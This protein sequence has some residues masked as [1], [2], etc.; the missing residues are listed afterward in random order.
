MKHLFFVICLVT[1]LC[2]S[3]KIE[4]FPVYNTQT[5]YLKGNVKLMIEKSQA[6]HVDSLLNYTI[7]TNRFNGI[8][9]YFYFSPLLELDSTLF[10]KMDTIFFGKRFYF[11]TSKTSQMFSS[12]YTMKGVIELETKISKYKNNIL[13]TKNYAPVLGYHSKTEEKWENSKIVWSKWESKL[14][15][16]YYEQL[17]EFDSNG[18]DTI[19]KSR[20]LKNDPFTI[21][22]VVYLEWDS[23]GNWTKRIEYNESDWTGSL[24]NRK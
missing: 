24:V 23:L 16:S 20:N 15:S 5:F 12:T 10:A 9:K 13:Y 11:K 7:D 22:K 4:T 21:Y 14:G 1:L 6:I 19:I 2:S 3:K 8:T 18:F 17:F